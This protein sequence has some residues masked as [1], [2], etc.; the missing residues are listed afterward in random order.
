MPDVFQNVAQAIAPLKVKEPR[1]YA[2][3]DLLNRQ[4]RDN[5]STLEETIRTVIGD[6]L[7]GEEVTSASLL[8]PSIAYSFTTRTV[9]FTW[10][11]VVDAAQ[12]EVRLGSSWD[13][14]SFKFR[15]IN[16]SADIDA[17]VYGTYNYLIKSINASG[18]YSAISNSISVTIPA[19]LPVA[20]STTVIDNTVLLYWTSPVSVFAIDYYQVFKDGVSLGIT[21]STFQAIFETAAGTYT[22]KI[23][24]YDIAG[25]VSANA[26]IDQLVNQPPDFVLQDSFTSTLNGT[27]T[28]MVLENQLTPNKI[29]GPF[30]LTRSWAQHFTDNG[31]TTI[32]NQIDA[33]FAYYGQ[34][35]KT[36]GAPD[37]SYQET[38]DFGVLFSATIATLTFNQ[39][40][41]DAGHDVAVTIKMA[42]SA[43]N[44][45]YTAFTTGASQFMTSMRYLKVKLEFVTADNRGLIEVW[46]L[47]VNIQVK[48][49]DDGAEVDAVSTD[50]S[51][52]SVVFTKAFKDIDKITA[53][54]KAVTPLTVVVDFVDVPNPTGFS[55]YVFNAA[56]VRV[57]NRVEWHAR[58][59]V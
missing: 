53:T 58:G 47:Q 26:E 44:I 54:A 1:L 19:I 38:I 50:V 33:G 7:A 55:V 14:A 25:N 27:L 51:G 56:G 3:L 21:R 45:T 37:G 43:D 15:T 36:G 29:V 12:Y 31:W 4:V 22:Y 2:A 10:T 9:R 41:V 20:I 40:I 5:N 30:D 52:T 34:P 35:T 16:L 28:N 57:S 39:N 6:V 13:T 17:L 48:R 11:E 49:E 8:P 46:N 42:W 23:L 24:A 59:I 32:Q 18:E